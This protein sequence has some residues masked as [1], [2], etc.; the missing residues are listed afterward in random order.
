MRPIQRGLAALTAALTCS[1][2]MS[3]AVADPSFPQIAGVLISGPFPEY[4]DQDYERA[5]SKYDT[6]ILN[7]YPGLK[8][9]GQTMESIMAYIKTQNPST[10]IFLYMKEDNV[11]T[12]AA[13][14]DALNEFRAKLDAQKWYVYASGTTGSPVASDFGADYPAIN[15]T[16]NT[17]PDANGDK[18]VDWMTKYFVTKFNST[19]VDGFFMDD[20]FWRTRTTGDWDLDGDSEAAHDAN[21][22]EWLRDGWAHYVSL[23]R[24]LM[25]GKTQIANIADWGMPEATLTEFQ[26]ILD[27]GLMEGMIGKTWS[28]ETTSWASMMAAYRKTMA[29]LGGPKLAIFNQW[30]EPTD[31]RSVRYGLGSALLDNAQYSFTDNTSKYHDVYWFDE[32]DANLGAATSAPPPVPSGA[33]QQGVYRRDFENGIVLV[34]PKGN[35]A[36]TVTLET[37]YLKLSS[38]GSSTNTK[39]HYVHDTT[40]NNGATVTSVTLQDR[41][42]IVLLRKTHTLGQT[43]VGTV[44]SAGMTADMKRGSKFTLAEA[45]TLS[46]FSAYLDGLGGASGTQNVRVVLYRDASG[47]PGAKVAESTTVSIASGAAASWVTFP[48]AQAAVLDPGAYWLVLHT[49]GTGSTLR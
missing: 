5:V 11:G 2:S 13:I 8:P 41:D 45:G 22:S 43:T 1:F 17:A 38:T 26:G 28:Y 14:G 27:G 6:M 9:Q 46:S 15:T 40:V 44:P 31:T 39:V 21:A 35:G 42:G 7:I 16:L 10:K 49:G 48:A 34:N 23:V 25:P 24:T 36:K 20:M 47:V 33:W 4:G 18:A 29:A 37:E 3:A 12:Q 19:S 30:G 32:F